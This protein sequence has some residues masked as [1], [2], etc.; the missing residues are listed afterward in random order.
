MYVMCECWFGAQKE[1]ILAN[2][3]HAYYKSTKYKRMKISAE[4]FMYTSVCN[5]LRISC[6]V[7]TT[8]EVERD[9]IVLHV[10]F[11]TCLIDKDVGR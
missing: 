5:P 1:G 4:G 8:S 2:R 7:G 3:K 9:D 11:F 6:G 10:L